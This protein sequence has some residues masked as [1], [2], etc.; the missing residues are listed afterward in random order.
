MRY[1]KITEIEALARRDNVR[2]KAVENFL[3][4]M[5]R[6]EI[7]K[8]D[9]VTN[10]ERDAGLYRWNVKTVSAIA[11]GIKLA[12]LKREGGENDRSDTV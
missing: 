8:K 7:S 5:G 9:A 4:S 2:Q 12:C 1:L 6:D 11:D 10:L 3:V